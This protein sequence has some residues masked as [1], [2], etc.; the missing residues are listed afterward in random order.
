MSDDNADAPERG[1][2]LFTPA[3]KLALALTALV[4]LLGAGAV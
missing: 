2:T 1:V 4:Y 3:R